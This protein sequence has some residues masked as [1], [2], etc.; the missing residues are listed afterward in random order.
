MYSCELGTAYVA[1]A[2]K[3]SKLYSNV[4][5]DVPNHIAEIFEMPCHIELYG[6]KTL[7]M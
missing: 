5:N 7:D 1:V 2:K 4:T 3:T 6:A